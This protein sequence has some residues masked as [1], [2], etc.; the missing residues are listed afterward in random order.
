MVITGRTLNSQQ[1]NPSPPS[2]PDPPSGTEQNKATPKPGSGRQ[3]RGGGAAGGGEEGGTHFKAAEGE[4]EG[5]VG[6]TPKDPLDRT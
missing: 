4:K 3:R 5:E 2:R 6:V 1:Q